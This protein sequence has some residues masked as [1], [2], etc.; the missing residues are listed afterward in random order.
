MYQTLQ[1]SIDFIKHFNFPPA[2]TRGCDQQ[3]QAVPGPRGLLRVHMVLGSN[4]ALQDDPPVGTVHS[5]EGEQ[6]L[7]PR[8][9]ESACRRFQ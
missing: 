4:L 3:A 8:P 9:I 2:N 7:G 6:D 5:A 1:K